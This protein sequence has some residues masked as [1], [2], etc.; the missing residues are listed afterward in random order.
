MALLGPE[1]LQKLALR[2]A[3]TTEAT[4]RAIC[5]I[6]G[7]ELVNPESSNFREFAVKLPGE[8]A[9]AVAHMDSAGVLGGFPLGGWWDSMS[10]CLLI[11]CDERTSNSDIEAL[12]S[13]MRS[14][15][16]EE[17]E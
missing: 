5:E 2:V 16:R 9:A 10:D 8:A 4:K 12:T 1:G 6:P 11:G 7:I 13:S 14:W 15:I 17:V 3:A